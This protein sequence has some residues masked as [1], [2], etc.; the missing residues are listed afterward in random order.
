MHIAI[1]HECIY[2]D[3]RIQVH[4]HRNAY[5]IIMTEQITKEF[6]VRIRDR[7]YLNRCMPFLDVILWIFVIIYPV[8]PSWTKFAK[9]SKQ[10][11]TVTKICI[12]PGTIQ[13]IN[14]ELSHINFHSLRA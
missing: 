1:R 2:L 12:T 6:G 10:P 14:H 5:Y 9:K 3:V 4:L 11:V 8:F 7:K 13:N